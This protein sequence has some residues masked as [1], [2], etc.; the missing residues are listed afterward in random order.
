MVRYLAKA[1][2]NLAFVGDS[3]DGA[4]ELF[5]LPLSFFSMQVLPMF[6]LLWC[7]FAKASSVGPDKGE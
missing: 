2:D 4:K 7:P 3:G 5:S 1:R 6:F